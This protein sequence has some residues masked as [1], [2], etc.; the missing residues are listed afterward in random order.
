MPQHY[1][2]TVY[3]VNCNYTVLDIPSIACRY[4]YAEM[5]FTANLKRYREKEKL[6]QNELGERVGVAQ[7]TVQRWETGKREPSFTD[8][9][10]LAKAL[11]VTVSD[12]F[13][14]R[15]PLD[16]PTAKQLESMVQTAMQ[17]LPIGATLGDY[18]SAVASSLR[19][20]LK[21]YRAAGGLLADQ[22]RE[23]AHGKVVQSPAP[24][25]QAARGERR[26]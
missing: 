20:Q 22:E 10:K 16:V 7:A 18:P 8:L 4:D 23:I 15:N 25:R 11:K 17:E 24:T 19:A 2:E 14:D 6:N 5:E 9:E 21:R 26:S 12:L 13:S 1:T 3:P